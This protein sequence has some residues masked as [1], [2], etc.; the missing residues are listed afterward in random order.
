M[1]VALL[2]HTF[3]VVLGIE[4]HVLAK[5]VKVGEEGEVVGKIGGIV[6]NV[7]V[8]ANLVPRND[9]LAKSGTD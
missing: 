7:E 8:V 2:K 9:I 3:N 1:T 5:N 6:P 4:S